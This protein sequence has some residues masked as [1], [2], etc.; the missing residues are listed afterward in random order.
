MKKKLDKSMDILRELNSDYLYL[1]ELSSKQ[2]LSDEFV[3]KKISELDEKYS[4][5][6]PHFN[7]SEGLLSNIGSDQ[8]S[9]NILNCAI[10]RLKSKKQN[11][12]KDKYNYDLANTILAKADIEAGN[13]ASLKTL[14]NSSRYKEAKEIFNLVRTSDKPHYERANTNIAN[15]LEKYGRNYE[16]LYAYDKPLKHNPNFGMALGNKAIAIEYYTKLAPQ[17][18]LALLNHSYLLLKQALKD[19]N[20]EEIGGQGVFNYFEQKL[21]NIE[22]YF[23]KSNFTPKANQHPKSISSYQS[24]ILDNNLY[25][26]YDFGYYYDKESLTDSFFLNL[27]ESLTSKRSKIS[28][29]SEKS[30]FCF[31]VFN[32]IMEDFV[33]SRFT[34]F[35]ALTSN[36]ENLDKTTNYIYTFD[37]T[38]HSLKFGMLKSAFSNLYNC[39]DKIAH[40]I[41]YYFCSEEISVENLNIY[42]EWLTTEE[43]RSTILKNGNHQLLA[44]YSLALDFKTNGQYHHLQN[45]RNRITHSFLNISTDFIESTSDEC[46]EISEEYLIEITNTMFI[47]VKAAIIYTNIAIRFCKN[48]GNSLPMVATLQNEIY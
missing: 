9:I 8:K 23:K 32:Q 24:F 30:Y 20:L 43:F 40:L 29:M 44:L 46:Y 35:K 17:Q 12:P 26:N 21:K 14:I 38:M 25:L 11:L 5:I 4:G 27:T 41:K 18:S 39:L 45:F 48:E 6:K 16:A 3:F 36:F 47:V 42:F 22:I 33:T 37:Y 19:E 13:P 28:F 34:F 2:K 10:K 15:I 31:H 1:S 7:S